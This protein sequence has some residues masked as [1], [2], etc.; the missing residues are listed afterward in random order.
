MEVEKRANGYEYPDRNNAKSVNGFY[1]DHALEGEQNDSL[2]YR[3]YRNSGQPKDKPRGSPGGTSSGWDQ[4]QVLQEAF[5]PSPRAQHHDAAE[6]QGLHRQSDHEPKRLI[7][8]LHHTLATRLVTKT[9][10][11]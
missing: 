7:C 1:G 11:L 5:L 8:H 2:E 4:S 9:L 3:S 6:A 10:Y